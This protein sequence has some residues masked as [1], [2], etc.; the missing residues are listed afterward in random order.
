LVR[1]LLCGD[2]A[3]T[4]NR[5]NYHATLVHAGAV[6]NLYDVRRRRSDTESGSGTH[7]SAWS[8][9]ADS[10][11]EYSVGRRVEPWTLENA[12]IASTAGT[13]A[14]ASGSTATAPGG[15]GTAGA[16]GSKMALGLTVK[17]TENL[18]PHTNH[19]I[20][21]VGVVN[22]SATA[23]TGSGVAASGATTAGPRQN[24][25]V[26]SFKMVSASCP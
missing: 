17:G 13:S 23:A 3:N 15:T 4:H 2:I 5:R 1:F 22:P 7:H 24:L 25:T 9:A 10:Y 19:K 12:E 18:K 20:Q 21:V 14:T 6:G 11:S 26:E 16:A 8:T